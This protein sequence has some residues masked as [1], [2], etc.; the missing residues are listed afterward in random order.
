[1]KRATTT[2][3]FRQGQSLFEIQ[4]LKH[5]LLLSTTVQ[6]DLTIRSTPGSRFVI[7]DMAGKTLQSGTVKAEKQAINLSTVAAG[8]YLLH[9]MDASGNTVNT[10]KFIKQ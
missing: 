9:V 5:N 7:Y 8:M 6:E 1:M 3:A 4:K 10:A 2:M